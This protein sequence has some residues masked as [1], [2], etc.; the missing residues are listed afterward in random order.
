MINDYEAT[1][2]IVPPQ[3]TI[4]TN[5]NSDVISTLNGLIEICKD[6]EFGFKTAEEGAE[7]QDLKSV[8]SGFS[9]QRAVFADVLQ[10]LVRS[11]G[12]EPESGGSLG[13]S[14]RRGWMDLKSAVTGNSDEAI[15]NE[16]ERMEDCAKDAYAK[17]LTENLPP[18]I[19]DVINQQSQAV[20]AAHNRVRSLRNAEDY[21]TATSNN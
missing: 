21:K 17:A 16:C 20:L 18:K 14:I 7:R 5:G 19:A 3:D 4:N 15:L 2:P 6:G 13:G 10:G 8:F 1:Q 11:L 9:Q 12:G